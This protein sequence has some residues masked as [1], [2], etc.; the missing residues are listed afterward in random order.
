[1]KKKIIQLNE[2]VIIF[3]DIKDFTLKTSLLTKKQLEGILNDHDGIITPIIKKY[4]GHIV[5]TF[6]DSFMIVFDKSEN[7]VLAC[8]EIQEKAIAYNST[9]KMG[10]FM[11]EF[12]IAI[13]K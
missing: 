12:R 11:I 9:K 2:S 3:T 13:D 10:L 1:V 6:G 4:K 7:A 8:I 5:K